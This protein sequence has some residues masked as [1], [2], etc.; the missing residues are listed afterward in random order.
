MALMAS[1][2]AGD[3]RIDRGCRAEFHADHGPPCSQHECDVLLRPLP[4]E[5]WEKSMNAASCGSRATNSV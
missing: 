2:H 1:R 4:V 3:G 5:V